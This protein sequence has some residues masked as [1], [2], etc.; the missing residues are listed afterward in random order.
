[1][2]CTWHLLANWRGIHGS[3]QTFIDSLSKHGPDRH[4]M[5]IGKIHGQQH[6]ILAGFHRAMP[7]PSSNA[8]G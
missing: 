6:S 7:P 4:T 2:T 1:V 3:A 8:W 5:D